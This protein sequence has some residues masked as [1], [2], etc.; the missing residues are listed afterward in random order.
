MRFLSSCL[1]G[2]ADDCGMAK[3]TGTVHVATTTRQYKGK[4]YTSHLLRRSYR[5]P[6]GKVKHQTLGNLSHLPDDL[7]QTIRQRLKGES[8]GNLQQ[9]GRASSI[10]SSAIAARQSGISRS[11]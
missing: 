7:I 3:R 10:P 5:D 6:D 4:V 1:D 8:I 11:A 2:C 9:M